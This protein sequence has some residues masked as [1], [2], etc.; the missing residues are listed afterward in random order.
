MQKLTQNALTY[1]SYTGVEYG[2]YMPYSLS[3]VYS[4]DEY[5]PEYN[6]AKWVYDNYVVTGKGRF[7]HKDEVFPDGMKVLWVHHDRVGV[8]SADCYNI[9]GG[10]T[11]RDKLSN[12]V[13]AG[14]NV[15]LSKQATRLVKDINR[16]TW[17]PRYG[18]G[19]Y[20]DGNDIWYM[21]SNF[22]A[23]GNTDR[24]NHPIF[25]YM[26]GYTENGSE[27][28]CKWPL[29]NAASMSYRR[30]DNNCLWDDWSAYNISAEPTDVARLNTFE[31]TQNCQILGGFG[32]T[33]ALDA[34]GLIEFLPD[35]TYAGK[36]IAMGLAAYQWTTVNNSSNMQNLTKG[37]L[38]YLATPE[39]YERDVRSGYFGTIC[40]PKASTSFTGAEMF[41]LD[42]KTADGNGIEL[43]Q[44]Y[45]LEAGKPYI[46]LA[47]ASK[48]VVTLTGAVVADAIP[49]KGLIGNLDD[50]DLSVPMD[51]LILKDNQLYIVDTD[52]VKVAKNRAYIDPTQVPAYPTTPKTSARRALRIHNTPTDV[53][54]LENTPAA[55][56]KIIRN[57]TLY[58]IH[59]GKTYNAQGQCIE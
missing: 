42:T 15:F 50:S 41:E 36:V 53:E 16:A 32:H 57:G 34:A 52:N 46:F 28:Y 17:Y 40:L 13:K 4:I 21:T 2:Y 24:H 11:F 25:T 56:R 22:V 19:G 59:D 38:T 23:C 55:D 8:N 6:S 30:T 39:T 10:D 58:I 44:V 3:E 43:T 20:G 12:F 45:A 35:A 27:G 14:G 48:L 54:A 51:K 18:D 33:T 37:I 26:Q 5:Q 9:L 49:N 31:S 7:I 1:L 47:N 29:L